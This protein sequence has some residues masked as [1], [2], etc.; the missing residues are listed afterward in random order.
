MADVSNQQEK[1]DWGESWN[2]NVA[3]SKVMRTLDAIC[4]NPYLDIIWAS[5]LLRRQIQLLFALSSTEK[6]WFPSMLSKNQ[7]IKNNS[8]YS[9]TWT[10]SNDVWLISPHFPT[11]LLLSSSDNS[12]RRW[13]LFTS[14]HGFQLGQQIGTDF[15]LLGKHRVIGVKTVGLSRHFRSMVAVLQNPSFFWGGCVSTSHDFCLVESTFF[16]VKK[17]LTLAGF[18]CN[19]KTYSNGKQTSLDESA[20]GISQPRSWCTRGILIGFTYDWYLFTITSHCPT[21]FASM[22]FSHHFSSTQKNHL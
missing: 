22:I 15:G 17:N 4:W 1:G 6:L 14:L 12:S 16:S 11:I 10:I 21:S 2:P 20:T 8:K 9:T 7:T 19:W 5:E 13:V 3:W 18:T